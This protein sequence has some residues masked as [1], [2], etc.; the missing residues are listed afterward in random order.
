MQENRQHRF[1]KQSVEDALLP[2]PQTALPGN[3][4]AK[5]PPA[6]NGDPLSESPEA[7]WYVCPE[8]GGQN[9][10]AGSMRE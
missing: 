7:Q 6:A 4:A 1:E 3:A 2:M 8:T 5:M 10:W 9:V